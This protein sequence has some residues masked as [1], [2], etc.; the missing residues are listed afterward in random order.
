MDQERVERALAHKW[1]WKYQRRN[2]VW[3][4]DL[5]DET[6]G[7]GTYTEIDTKQAFRSRT[8]AADAAAALNKAYQ[9]GIERGQAE[10]LHWMQEHGLEDSASLFMDVA[11]SKE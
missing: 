7:H 8:A 11:S 9:A 6:G 2:G 1:Y 3:W 4:V 10:V 5:F